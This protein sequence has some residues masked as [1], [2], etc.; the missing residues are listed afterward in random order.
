VRWISNCI[1]TLRK[2]G[3]TRIE[4]A[5]QAETNWTDHEIWRKRPPRSEARKQREDC[6]VSKSVT[7]FD[8]ALPTKL[9]LMSELMSE[10]FG[11]FERGS[12]RGGVDSDS[13]PIAPPTAGASKER[14]VEHRG[15]DLIRRDTHHDQHADTRSEQSPH[16][17]HGRAL[18]EE[19]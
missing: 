15:P 14:A 1:D 4:P 5:A 17:A 8:L 16:D 2:A 12:A 18:D 3:K 9:S 7:R 6:L 13:R 10:R 11:R 19:L